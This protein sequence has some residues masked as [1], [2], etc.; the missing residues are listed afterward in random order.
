MIFHAMERCGVTDVQE[1]L[2]VGDTP[3]DLQAGK[4]GGVLG[5]IGVLPGVHNR[6]RLLSES[7][8][9]LIP[10]VAAIPAL[11]EAHYL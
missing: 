6:D 9:H 7:P 4:R 11:A 5:V 10:S 1:V 3:L 2:T 8:S